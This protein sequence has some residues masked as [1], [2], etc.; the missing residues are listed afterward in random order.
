M[1]EGQSIAVIFDD[2]NLFW[3]TPFENDQHETTDTLAD[4]HHIVH[5]IDPASHLLL[6][7]VA[8]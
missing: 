4:R 1:A 6:V 3:A 2:Y 5:W 7:K 8:R